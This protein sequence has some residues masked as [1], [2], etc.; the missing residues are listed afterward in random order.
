MATGNN[1]DNSGAK[2]EYQLAMHKAIHKMAKQMAEATTK[3]HN[4]IEKASKEENVHGQE[5]N[6][7]CENALKIVRSVAALVTQ[8]NTYQ[9]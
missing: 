1:Q 9:K 2:L 6:E 3:Y 8:L 7:E 4:D 5:Y